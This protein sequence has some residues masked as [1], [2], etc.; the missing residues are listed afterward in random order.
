LAVVYKLKLCLKLENPY[1]R[2]LPP[3]EDEDEGDREPSKR[4]GQDKKKRK[5]RGLKT[6]ETTQQF[7]A[8]KKANIQKEANAAKGRLLGMMCGS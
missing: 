4:R 7:Q 2:K 6:N 8:N 1:E 3:Q 5:Y